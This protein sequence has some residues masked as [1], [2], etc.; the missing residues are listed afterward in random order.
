MGTQRAIPAADRI[1]RWRRWAKL[2]CIAADPLIIEMLTRTFRRRPGCMSGNLMFTTK[3]TTQRSDFACV[4]V[5]GVENML[6]HT[7]SCGRKARARRVRIAR[8]HHAWKTGATSGAVRHAGVQ[9]YF[10]RPAGRI[11][12]TAAARLPPAGRRICSIDQ[13][14]DGALISQSWACACGARQLPAPCRQHDQAG[15]AAPSR[16]E[17]R[18]SA[19]GEIERLRAEIERLK[20]G[21]EQQ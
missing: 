4:V 17:P 16:T 5:K 7:T 9:E 3:K 13:D 19:P 18:A 21:S 14:A 8:A 12:Q 6:R 20:S 2:M 1:Q 15:I 11:P 10:L